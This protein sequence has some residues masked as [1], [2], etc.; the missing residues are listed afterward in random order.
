MA[1]KGVLKYRKYQRINSHDPEAAPM[2]YAKAAPDR[3]AVLAW[4][5]QWGIDRYAGLCEG[6]GARR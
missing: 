4:G 6:A 5:H 2:W 1:N 3:T